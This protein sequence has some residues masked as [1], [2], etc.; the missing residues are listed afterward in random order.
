MRG[1]PERGRRGARGEPER[2]GLTALKLFDG[3]SEV[4]GREEGGS[5]VRLPGTAAEGGRR[6]ERV[7]APKCGFL[8]TLP[9]RTDKSFGHKGS[10][11]TRTTQ[12]TALTIIKE[13]HTNE[14]L[15]QLHTKS[16]LPDKES[17]FILQQLHTKSSVLGEE[18]LSD[19]RQEESTSQGSKLKKKVSTHGHQVRA[20]RHAHMLHSDREGYTETLTLCPL[21]PA[22]HGPSSPLSRAA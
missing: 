12:E 6:R 21:R 13:L 7:V 20:Y 17:S 16:S 11:L 22:S 1:E 9:R 15:Q 5:W 14:L 3:I 19:L 2:G 8:Q 18:S 4:G 10:R